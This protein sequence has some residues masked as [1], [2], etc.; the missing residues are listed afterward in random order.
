MH[1]NIFSASDIHRWQDSAELLG[2]LN[3]ICR[4]G[5]TVVVKM[6][7]TRSNGALFTVVLSGGLLGDDYFHKEGPD[8]K[9]LLEQAVAFYLKAENPRAEG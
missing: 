4:K 5:S 3:V 7:G 8:L 2:S 6:D 1:P 9:P